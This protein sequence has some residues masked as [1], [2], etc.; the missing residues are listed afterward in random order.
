MYSESVDVRCAFSS[1]TIVRVGGIEPPSQPWEGRILPLDHT[2]MIHIL[3]ECAVRLRRRC[4]LCAGVGPLSIQQTCPVLDLGET[5]S[6][7]VYQNLNH[8]SSEG[9]GGNGNTSG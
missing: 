5:Q 3:L 7:Q 2:R 4:V 9:F 1:L 8:S 6:R